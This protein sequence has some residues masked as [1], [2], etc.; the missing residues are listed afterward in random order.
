MGLF[1]LA[2]QLREK[3][4]DIEEALVE[5]KKMIDNLRKEYDTLSKKVKIVATNLNMAEEALEA[6]QREKQQRLNELLV[7]IPLKL[8]QIEYVVFGEI[9]SDLSGTLVFSNHSLGRLQERIVQLHEENSQ[10]QKLNKECRER[11]KQLTREKREMARTIQKMQETVSQLMVSKFGRVI[12]LEA[13]QTLSVNTTLEELKIRKLRKEL[14]N[15]KEMKMWEEKIAQVRWELMMKTKEHT[16]KLHQMNDLCIEK[17]KLDSQLNILQNQQGNAF[18]GPRKADT[19]AREKVTELIHV[20]A[21]RI[22]ALKEEV[23]LLR[24]K[25][26]LVLPPIHSP[27]ENE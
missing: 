19:V 1:E 18:Q 9:P 6:Y 23:A 11:R 16:K 14:S 4:L 5:E 15:A 3:R 26:G 7:V 24:K 21:E 25:G 20:Q 10:Q 22:L 8:H 12:N 13:L 2:L 17:K 27:Q